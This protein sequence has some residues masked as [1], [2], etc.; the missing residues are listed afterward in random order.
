MNYKTLA[1][2]IE[3]D[4]INLDDPETCNGISNKINA[5][6]GC[7]ENN[8]LYHN[9]FHQENILVDT[10]NGN[11]IGILD[12]GLADKENNDFTKNMDY[13]CDGLKDIKRNSTLRSPVSVIRNSDEDFFGGKRR[14]SRRRKSSKKSR[15][16]SS[17]SSKKSRSSI[18]SRRKTKKYKK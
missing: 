16:K 1:E 3:K 17:I 5:I 4:K 2:G 18:S 11:K 10:E 15:R 9:D 7:M 12:F 13:T 6:R 8:S 14:K